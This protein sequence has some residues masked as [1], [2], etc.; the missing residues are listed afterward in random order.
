MNK[1][2]VLLITFILIFSN[3]SF[4]KH[5]EINN[6]ILP[7]NIAVCKASKEHFNNYEPET[8][9]KTNN[10]LRKPGEFPV[11]CGDKLIVKGKVVD[12]NCVPI[13]DAKISIWQVACDGK[14]PYKPLRSRFNNKEI[15]LNSGATF[16]GAGTTSTD[17]KGE[18]YFITTYPP[19]KGKTPP[20]IN[21]RVSHMDFEDFDTII[22]PSQVPAEPEP[23]DFESP[24]FKIEDTLVNEFKIVVPIKMKMREF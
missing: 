16:L 4:A 19:S 6:K 5:V 8:F 15:N 3:Q 12:K 18:F 11:F 9:P 10:L 2:F 1:Y 20:H 13:P 7:A 14:Y 24:R 21:V 22:F 17:N 23:E